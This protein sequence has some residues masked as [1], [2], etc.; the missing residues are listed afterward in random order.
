M[1]PCNVWLYGQGDLFD[2]AAAYAF[3]LA[4]AQAFLDGT[5]RTGVGAALVFLEG[6]GVSVPEATEALYAAMIAVAER[7]MTH[8]L[9]RSIAP[10]LRRRRVTRHTRRRSFF[11]RRLQLRIGLCDLWSRFAQPKA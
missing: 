1:H 9:P 2:I 11:M 6:N 5:K 4:Q 8:S 10:L 7:R 3:H